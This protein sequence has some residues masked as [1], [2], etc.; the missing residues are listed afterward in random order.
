MT[1]HCAKCGNRFLSGSAGICYTCNRILSEEVRYGRRRPAKSAA[2]SERP[3]PR[4]LS[5]QE[6]LHLFHQGLSPE[7]IAESR[8]LKPAT[9]YTHLSKLIEQ[10]RLSVSE[11]LT[12][13]MC[14]EVRD[15]YHLVPSPERAEQVVEKLRRPLSTDLVAF[16]LGALKLQLGGGRRVQPPEREQLKKV[17]RLLLRGAAPGHSPYSFVRLLQGQYS[18]EQSERHLFGLYHGYHRDDLL[19]VARLLVS[20]Q[21]EAA[22]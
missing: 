16:A 10:G 15:A 14:E 13:Q 21:L 17:M 19:E 2:A 3:K 8:G 9:I 12:P 22:S 11:V 18:P 6:T 20:E 7:A 1:G 5:H 4:P